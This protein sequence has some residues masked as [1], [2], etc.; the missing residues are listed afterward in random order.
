MK[1]KVLCQLGNS[2]YPSVEIFFEISI[3]YDPVWQI[4]VSRI[5]FLKNYCVAREGPKSAIFALIDLH[6]LQFD[7]GIVLAPPNPPI[8]LK[9]TKSFFLSVL[10]GC[11][12]KMS[13][14]KSTLKTLTPEILPNLFLIFY[15]CW[16]YAI[17]FW[18]FKTHCDG[19][20]HRHQCPVDFLKM[21]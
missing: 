6:P 14:Y 8:Y 18:D 5:V 21:G 12:V 15:I 11:L 13:Q 1:V 17:S 9:M 20:D 10:F 7:V 4:S 2:F 3:S 16:H 19:H